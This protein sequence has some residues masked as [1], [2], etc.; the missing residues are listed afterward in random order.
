[1]TKLA[2]CGLGANLNQPLEQLQY[3]IEQLKQNPDIQFLRRSSW[4]GSTAVGPGE[5]PDYVNGV[6]E[7][8]TELS[9]ED[10]LACFHKIEADCGRKR[11]IRW[12]ARTLDLDLLWFEGRNSNQAELMLPHPRIAERN[13]VLWPWRELNPE[14]EIEGLGRIETLASQLSDGGLWQLKASEESE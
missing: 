4:Y 10:L 8:Q 3:A 6:A 13:F 2:Y 14:L 11:I 5:Q 1:M 12:G 9:A 7:L